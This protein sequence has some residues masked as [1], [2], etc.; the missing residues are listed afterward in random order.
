[1]FRFVPWRTSASVVLCAFAMSACVVPRARLSEPLVTD[2]PDFTESAEAIELGHAQ[3]EAGHT[4]SRVGSESSQSIGEVLFRTGLA[5]RAELRVGLNS[6]AISRT[7]GQPWSGGRE[8]GSLGVKV[9]LVEGG[10]KGSW[11]PSVSLLGKTSVPSGA[12]SER[13][14]AWQPETKL[15]AGW[16]LTDRIDFTSNVNAAA[17]KDGTWHNE[18]AVSGS[19]G[20]GITDKIRTYAEGYSFFIG[21]QHPARLPYVNAGATYQFTPDLQVDLRGGSGVHRSFT[22]P[23][24]FVGLGISRRW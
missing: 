15:I 23:D 9:R 16:T 3:L 17:V 20:F 6:Y 8:D 21:G 7:A 5:P 22:G 19:L 11:K 2:R 14:N 13:I 10:E 24:Y 4:F 12:A 18:Y 1:M